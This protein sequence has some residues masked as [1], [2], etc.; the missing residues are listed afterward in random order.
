MER[1][2]QATA[3]WK[4]VPKQKQQPATVPTTSTLAKVPLTTSTKAW[5]LNKLT[6]CATMIAMIW[7]HAS[8]VYSTTLNSKMRKA[9]LIVAYQKLTTTPAPLAQ[10]ARP[11]TTTPRPTN[12]NMSEWTI[13]RLPNM[14]ALGNAHPAGGDPLKLVRAMQTALC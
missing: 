2:Q 4:T 3:E 9:G 13:C 7:E 6:A 10:N 1:T 11:A 8:A 14:G 12:P 5:S